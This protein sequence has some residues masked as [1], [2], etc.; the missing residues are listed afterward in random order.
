MSNE[1]FIP[2]PAQMAL[3]PDVSGNKI[4]GLGETAPRRPSYVYWGNDPDEIAHGALQKWFYTVDPGL[5]EY[6]EIRR[7]RALV[8]DQ[9]LSP[10][11]PNQMAVDADAWRAFVDASI[12]AGDFDKAGATRFDPQWAF[13]GVE[14]H[15]RHIIILGFQHTYDKILQAPAPE[16]GLEVMRQYLRAAQGAKQVAGWLRERGWDAEPLT[17]PMSGKVTMIPPALAAGFGELGKHGSVI[18]PAFGASFRLSAVLTD[19]PLPLD[20][21]ADHGIDAFCA[22]CRVCEAACPTDAI[23][24]HK[25]TVRGVEKWYVDFD[26]CLP[27]F[28]QHQGC[29]VCIAVCPWSRPGVGDRLVLKLAKRAERL[30]AKEGGAG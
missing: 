19:C 2:D 28:N 9:A 18:N 25:Q 15:Q 7:E 30:A 24:P 27:F 4:N 13:E 1:R 8:L 3:F 22:S 14:I 17:G 12:A 21:P 23:A 29:A 11:A 16:G 5:A 10:L 6:A 26:R 20:A